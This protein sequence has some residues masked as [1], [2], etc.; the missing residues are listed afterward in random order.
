MSFYCHIIRTVFV[1][2]SNSSFHLSVCLIVKFHSVFFFFFLGMNQW[3]WRCYNLFP[4][5]VFE[6]QQQKERCK[7]ARNQCFVTKFMWKRSINSIE[8][9]LIYEVIVFWFVNRVSVWHSCKLCSISIHMKQPSEGL[10]KTI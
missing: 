6:F 10:Q 5:F 8:N 9:L 2:D 4:F 7:A 1:D 3:Y